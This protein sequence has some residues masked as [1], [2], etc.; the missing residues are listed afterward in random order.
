MCSP[1][2]AWSP[3][4]LVSR[5]GLS[6]AE[7]MVASLVLAVS[8]LRVLELIRWAT[9]STRV[10]ELDLAARTAA[11][12]V[13]E[14]LVGPSAYADPLLDDPARPFVGTE[15][16][17]DLVIARDP[18]LRR[19]HALGSL[20]A[21]H[22]PRV[23]IAIEAPYGHPAVGPEVSLEAYRVTLSW[24]DADGRRKEATVARLHHPR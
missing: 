2:A 12:D 21:S 18:A 13:L 11:G 9:A 22:E 17:L 8:M 24:F 4:S 5:G 1:A 6:L 20:L 3:S 10:T 15:V 23:L 16:P 19:D 7:V 14:R